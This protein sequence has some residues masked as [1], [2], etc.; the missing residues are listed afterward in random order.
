[1]K[2]MKK[3]TFEASRLIT[4][5]SLDCTVGEGGNNLLEHAIK[6]LKI[7]NSYAKD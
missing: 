3:E 5:L 6:V 1:M 2:M 7:Q 4:S